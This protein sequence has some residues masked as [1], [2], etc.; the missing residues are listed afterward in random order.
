MWH[1][2]ERNH[3]RLIDASG[4]PFGT[5]RSRL[6]DIATADA[7]IND[8]HITLTGTGTM[9][10]EL[11]ALD[12]DG[13]TLGTVHSSAISWHGR[14]TLPDADPLALRRAPALHLKWLVGQEET[15]TSVVE[16]RRRRVHF[17]CDT[18]VMCTHPALAALTMY[19]MQHHRA[20]S[21]TR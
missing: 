8:T 1:R 15:P 12:E 20:G 3:Y 14:I 6:P 7:T 21:M 17:S 19:L 2:T 9:R 18:G 10:R 16:V 11:T 5:Y 13:Q 4:S